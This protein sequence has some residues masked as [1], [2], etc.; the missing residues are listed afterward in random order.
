MHCISVLQR[1]PKVTHQNVGVIFSSA[2][3]LLVL[4]GQDVVLSPKDAVMCLIRRKRRREMN[5]RGTRHGI[6]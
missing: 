5:E 1:I 2:R 4:T 6:H 3:T